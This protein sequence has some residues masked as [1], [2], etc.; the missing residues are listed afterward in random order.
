MKI[1]LLSYQVSQ[2][3]LLRGLILI[4]KP[5]SPTTSG[6]S[7]SGKSE[8]TKLIIKYLTIVSPSN[9]AK[10]KSWVEEQILEANTILES[11]GNAKTVRNDNSSRFGKLVH[12]YLS[13][14]LNIVGAS[15]INYLLEKSRVVRQSK[16]ER[17]YHIF[18][19]F[20]AG[21]TKEEREK[22]RLP[23][24]ATSFAY[25][26]KSNCIDI[27]GVNDKQKFDSL[28]LALNVVKMSSAEL[29]KLFQ[30]ISGILHLG[31]IEFYHDDAKDCS[32]IKEE[33]FESISIV[34]QMLEIPE[35]EL[36]RALTF[37]QIV[38]RKEV[39]NVPLKGY[40]A[41]DNRDSISKTIY[42]KLFD[43]IVKFINQST[44]IVGQKNTFIGILDI[45][46]FENFDINS[47]EQLCINYT[48]EKLQQFFNL[49]IFK[50]EQQE[51][52][53]DGVKLDKIDFIDNQEALD[54]IEGK[55]GLIDL[56]DEECR[57]PNSND[58]TFLAKVQKNLGK[59]ECYVKP[60][61][62]SPEFSVVHYAGKV[63]YRVETFIDKNR[64]TV[65]EGVLKIFQNS[66]N[67]ILAKIF[68]S[69]AADGKKSGQ[70]K[71]DTAASKFKEQLKLLM[72]TLEQTSP[73]YIRCIKPNYEKKAF[74]FDDN[75]T[76]SQ[77]RY[78]GMLE[79]IRIRKAGFP[80]KF[81]YEKFNDM[82]RF[83]ESPGK[84]PNLT[85]VNIMYKCNVNRAH[86]KEGK[87]KIFMKQD[88]LDLLIDRNNQIKQEYVIMVQKT[89]KKF[90]AKKKYDRMI[91]ATFFLQSYVKMFT[92]RQRYLKKR[93][94]IIKIQSFVRGWFAR[95][96]FRQLKNE[97]NSSKF[98]ANDGYSTVESFTT[99]SN[100]EEDE[101]MLIEE[102]E[103]KLLALLEEKRVGGMKA[104]KVEI[105]LANNSN[106]ADRDEMNNQF[107]EN[108]SSDYQSIFYGK[109]NN[110]SGANQQINGQAVG[111]PRALKKNPLAQNVQ[112]GHDEDKSLRAFAEKYF[113]RQSAA[114]MTTMKKSNE[115]FDLDQLLCFSRAP[116][117]NTLVKMIVKEK[118]IGTAIL[119]FKLIT[120]VVESDNLDNQECLESV[121]KIMQFAI[122]SP[123]ARD[124]VYLQL[125][126]Q[127]TPN[128]K[129]KNM[130]WKKIGL[131]GWL[132]MTLYCGTFAPSKTFSKYL[133]HYLSSTAEQPDKGN[134]NSI[135]A[136]LAT[137][138]E[139]N[140]RSIL[141]NG[142]RKHVPSYTEFKSLK[143][144]EP[145]LCRF[146]MFDGQ[147]K[148]FPIR[149]TT[150]ASE[151]VEKLARKM[152]L[153]DHNGWSLCEVAV[154]GW[155]ERP[156][157]GTEYIADVISSWEK[158]KK[159]SIKTT[160]F[161]TVRPRS[162]S[163]T[164]KK[165]KNHNARQAIGDGEVKLY[166]KKRIFKD[167][168]QF[169]SD[170]VEFHLLYSQAVWEVQSGNYPMTD[171]VAAQLAALQIQN[172]FGDAE[173]K[174]DIKVLNLKKYIPK[175]VF[176]NLPK[177]S[178]IKS[179]MA[180]HQNFSGKSS[181]QARMEYLET[182]LQFKHYGST[183]FSVR[184]DG[185]WSYPENIV[186]ALNSSA[187]HFMNKKRMI[188]QSWSYSSLQ[189]WE[190]EPD[191]ITLTFM[192]EN[193]QE[194]E[195]AERKTESF[196][197][198]SKSAEDINTTLMVYS[199]KTGVEKRKDKGIYVNEAELS[200]LTRDLEKARAT[201][202]KK[203]LV[204]FESAQMTPQSLSDLFGPETLP[205]RSPK[206]E[207]LYNVL[208]EWPKNLAKMRPPILTS[209]SNNAQI[210]PLAKELD[211]MITEYKD[212]EN[213]ASKHRDSKTKFPD[214]YLVQN[215]IRMV[216]NTPELAD[217]LFIN[218][219]RNTWTGNLGT[220]VKSVKIWR[221][222]SVCLGCLKP[223][224]PEVTELLR[225]HLRRFSVISENTPRIHI[226]KEEILHARHC[227]KNFPRAM[228][229]DLRK[230]YPGESEI[231]CIMFN[232]P[233]FTR[234]HMPDGQYRAVSFDSHTKVKEL[235]ELLQEKMNLLDTK[236]FAMYCRS[237]NYE[238]ALSGEEFVCDLLGQ[239]DVDI[240]EGKITSLSQ[241][242]QLLMKKRLFMDPFTSSNTILE[243][244]FI[245]VQILQ[246]ILAR[247]YP[248]SYEDALYLAGLRAQVESGD[249]DPARHNVHRLVM[250]KYVPKHLHSNQMISL[251]QREHAEFRGLSAADCRE[252]FMKR[253]RSWPLFG[254]AV[255]EVI[256]SYTGD[257]PN[258][259]WLLVNRENILLMPRQSKQALLTIPLSK[260]G[261]ISPDTNS[262]MILTEDR[263]TKIVL[264]T[265]N[266]EEIA[267]LIADYKNYANQ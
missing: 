3:L 96:Y 26:N 197:F 187:I 31:N 189:T 79:T 141:I 201:V 32:Q 205:R 136:R 240:K 137:L 159:S 152:N 25:L 145:M 20:L 36:K 126:R 7:G 12:I 70:K 151:V 213:T 52:A 109:N 24:N 259:C 58:Q 84:N 119:S 266:G 59:R 147:I 265:K 72:Q 207:E 9:G 177:D 60:K 77:L 104:K 45:F 226:P 143:R 168:K 257:F 5:Y 133:L 236:G 13:S 244:E 254:S 223:S 113:N 178:W 198:I 171:S 217:E 157:R 111:V 260:L 176:N 23:K 261:N 140:V 188:F 183:T 63:T 249:E 190:T 125:I 129:M 48:N 27:P 47:F 87:T 92:Y 237:K 120:K 94:A 66:K 121:S 103:K 1:N 80:I 162:K 124:E 160:D 16:S 238:V 202:L 43:Y 21:A 194:S 42:G 191:S 181:V 186:L 193:N 203:K 123:E 71:S 110:Q 255:F 114:F 106:S 74:T 241:V 38:V 99:Y 215:I 29:E 54:L 196:R 118:I 210:Y 85:T 264:E 56:L 131:N 200:V 44:K 167:V 50:L 225:C 40:Q 247:R 173:K 95:D 146:F 8:A 98:G 235:L 153:K 242:P 224:I 69:E 83:I 37:R 75:L 115:E 89:W 39:T 132:I 135:F 216:M 250:E 214:W 34:S 182:L 179:I 88:A 169:P 81:L 245:Q 6:E 102:E 134:E 252:A 91:K 105:G 55:G 150:L 195:P 122:E 228:K 229:S 61:T 18:Y 51:Y 209:S 174:L 14:S 86:Y 139:R 154:D 128:P 262:V 10:N 57:L 62:A 93:E 218:L 82:F 253:I 28:R 49:Y 30:I 208:G 117:Q 41:F 101:R 11:F 2:L 78:A 97:K 33:S 221:L 65:Q 211:S 230:F 73:H 165:D 130:N 222:L 219:I 15:I 127:I 258:Q 227:N 156:V 64:D 108:F 17:N 248:L 100:A 263:D 53:K 148:A 149:Q 107:K 170:P 158:E 251:I 220:D 246:E 239:W 67:P 234:I 163:T 232:S 144:N 192:P 172:E 231:K 267:G 116:L 90:V 164:D 142:T 243:E 256:Q 184:F 155:L 233:V 180:Y 76:L 68:E 212:Q 166:L 161:E 19:E 185:Y 206:N 204:K 112:H 175:S 4:N 138:A 199:E 46:G 35:E 22:Y